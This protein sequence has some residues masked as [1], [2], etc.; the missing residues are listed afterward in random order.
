D[1]EYSKYEENLSKTKFALEFLKR[2]VP[3]KSGLKALQEEKPILTL[4]ELDSKVKASSWIGSYEKAKEK[5]TQLINLDS[6]VTK[7]QA[8]IDTLTHW[9]DLDVA[10]D[11]LK[12]LKNTSYFLG[13]IAKSYED[14][15]IE[16]LSNVFVEIISR[17]NNDIN[18][19][20]LS[21]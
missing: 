17:S 7:L 8:E 2:Y 6:R 16:Q 3:K 15:L 21:N 14:T 9:Q 13:T 4:D 5:E 19:L 1:S 12:E 18:L 10:F 20:I 11:E